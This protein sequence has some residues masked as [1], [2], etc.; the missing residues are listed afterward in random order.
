M[1]MR[2]RVLEIGVAIAWV[3]GVCAGWLVTHGEVAES[4]WR[5]LAIVRVA[6]QLGTSVALLWCFPGVVTAPGYVWSRLAVRARRAIS[7][8]VGATLGL[9]L[10]H[11]PLLDLVAG[12]RT[13]HGKVDRIATYNGLSRQSNYYQRSFRV[14]I[15]SSSVPWPRDHDPPCP[16]GTEITAVTL[17]H[18][19]KLLSVR[20]GDAERWLGEWD[21]NF[22]RVQITRDLR[23]DGRVLGT[24]ASERAH[25]TF[26]G[27]ASFGRLELGWV[28]VGTWAYGLATLELEAGGS[29]F[30]GT[31]SYA[32]REQKP[33]GDWTGQRAVR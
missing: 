13:V 30:H 8:P 6:W 4:E 10:C 25:G 12:E 5:V 27:R 33:R 32:D 19:D 7:V 22:G 16:I 20:C 9:L 17:E 3:A 21:T 18:L 24:Y 28:E 1:S 14:L 23:D 29:G 11:G 15:D 31:W 2:H 26:E